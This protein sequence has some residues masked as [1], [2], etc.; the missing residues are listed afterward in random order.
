MG[1][2]SRERDATAEFGVFFRRGVTLGASGVA[3]AA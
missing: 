1:Q 3:A 2:P